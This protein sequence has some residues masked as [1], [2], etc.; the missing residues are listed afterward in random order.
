MY[1]ESSF[2]RISSWCNELGVGNSLCKIFRNKILKQISEFKT[3]A[4][5]KT[6]FCSCY[7]KYF[8]Q[9]NV[10]FSNHLFYFNYFKWIFNKFF[11]FPVLK[12]VKSTILY[13]FFIINLPITKNIWI[14]LNFKLLI[15]LKL[16]QNNIFHPEVRDC[17]VKEKFSFVLYYIVLSTC[18]NEA[19]RNI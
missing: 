14:V 19:S 3:W 7:C 11:D 10:V 8:F 6:R 15:L 12:I 5:R 9:K 2:L 18:T 1:F 4:T 16:I 13:I 17:L